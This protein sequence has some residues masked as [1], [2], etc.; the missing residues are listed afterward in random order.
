MFNPR[1]NKTVIMQTNH[2]KCNTRV[3]HYW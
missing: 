1:R 2:V 3:L